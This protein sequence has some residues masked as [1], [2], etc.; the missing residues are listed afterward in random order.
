MPT[1]DLCHDAVVAALIKAGWTVSTKS[2]TLVVSR[3][4]PLQ[5]DIRARRTDAFGAEEQLLVEVKCF[6]ASSSD[7]TELYSAIGQYLVY[8]DLL[9]ERD[10]G[11]PLYLALPAQ[12]YRDVVTRLA[13]R[14]TQRLNIRMILIDIDREVVEQ[15]LP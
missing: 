9:Q 12:K 2:Y 14:L 6:P 11:V 15:W 7:T 1:Y 10:I 4:R 8:R 5:I 13:G 3:G